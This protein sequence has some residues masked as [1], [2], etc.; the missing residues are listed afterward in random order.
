MSAGEL[1]LSNWGGTTLFDMQRLGEA[2]L[3]IR[4]F[5]VDVGREPGAR[6]HVQT[7]AIEVEKE[8]YLRLRIIRAVEANDVVVLIFHPDAAFE[9][10]DFLIFFGLNIDHQAANFTQELTADEVEVVVLLLKIGGENHHLGKAH[11]QKMQ[12]INPG[13]FTQQAM[14]KT[15]LA[16]EGNVFRSVG[17]IETAEVILIA[18]GN[19]VASAV[20]LIVL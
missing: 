18:S 19:R 5:G 12:G 10:S 1:D 16:D 14:S 11:R 13:Q 20:G 8:V 2:G 15:G 4:C 9:A 6:T 17:H 7:P 3:E